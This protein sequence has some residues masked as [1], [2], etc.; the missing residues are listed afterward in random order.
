V[1]LE[2][3]GAGAG[4]ALGGTGDPPMHLE[5]VPNL[6]DLRPGDR[7][8]T[9]GLDGIFP[10]GFLI[11]TVEKAELANVARRN[12][13]VRPAV[14]FTGLDVVLVVRTQTPGTVR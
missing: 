7:L 8:L 3:T 14:D 13:T 12:V 2:R 11:G 6:I 1:K 4:N 10:P 5:Q 9:S